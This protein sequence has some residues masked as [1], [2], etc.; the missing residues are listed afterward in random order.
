MTYDVV[1]SIRAE[2]SMVEVQP[3]G[4]HNIV[5]DSIKLKGTEQI[6]FHQIKR[7]DP[8]TY[9][10]EMLVRLLYKAFPADGEA[11]HEPAAPSSFLPRRLPLD[12]SHCAE[13]SHLRLLLGRRPR[14][15]DART[16]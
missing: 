4:M 3:R 11:C 15:S 14:P 8:H 10:P 12:G 1:H 9:L 16:I 5:I 13:A 7:D 6:P 2:G